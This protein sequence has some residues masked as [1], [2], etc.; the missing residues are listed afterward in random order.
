M[1]TRPLLCSALLVAGFGALLIPGAAS[2]RLPLGRNPAIPWKLH[3]AASLPAASLTGMNQPEFA[4]ADWIAAQVPGTVFSSCVA[5]GLEPDPNFGDNITKVDRTRYDQDFWY[6]TE[7][8]VPADFN[9]GRL[10]L[11]FLGVNRDAE[12]FLN[13]QRLGLI[14]GIVQRGRFDVT[15]AVRSAGPNVLTVLVHPPLAPVSNGASPTYGSSGGWDWMPSVPGYNS[16]IQDDVFVTTTGDVSIID[17]WIQAELPRLDLAQ[18]KLQVELL[19]SSSQG[20]KGH[21]VG[22][23]EPGAISFELPVTLGPRESKPITV[24]HQ[25]FPALAIANPAL[26]WPNGY[27]AP[28]LYRCELRFVAAS[29][30]SSDQQEVPFGIRQLEVDTSTRA[31]RVVVN[32][33]PIF[34]TGGNWGMPEFLLRGTPADYDTRV[35]LHQDM[36]FNMIRNWMGS[37]TNDAFYT[38]CDRYGILV[39][40][41]FWLNSSGGLPRDLLVFHAN[42]IEKLKRLRNH[43]CI[44]LWCGSNEGVPPAPLDEWLAT[45]VKTFDGR[46]YHSNSHSGSLSGSGPWT[47]LAPEEYFL[48]AAPGNWGGEE[49]WGMRSEMGAAAFVN[50]D[51]LKEFIPADKLWP[52]NDAWDRHFFGAAAMYAGPDTYAKAIDDR[53]GAPKGIEEFCRKAQLL[54]IETNK[55]MFEGWRDNLWHDATG[56]LIWM[57]QSAFPSMVWQTYDYYFDATGAYWG[58]KSACEPVH[59][60]WNLGTN[61][62]KAINNTRT[63][64]TGVHAE[65]R[66]YGLDG[67][68]LTKLKRS[69]T[70]DLAANAA[71][72]CFAAP[73][74]G[75]DLARGRPVTVS[76]VHVPSR[77]G[78]KLTDGR[79]D[80][81]WESDFA[82]QPWLIVD[83]GEPQSIGR[84]IMRWETGVHAHIYKLQTSADGNVWRDAYYQQDGRGGVEEVSFPAVTTRYLRMFCQEKATTVGISMRAFEVYADAASVPAGVHF[85]R[86]RLT[87]A[88]GSLLS[89]NLY[90]R[91]ARPL[92]YQ[93]LNTLPPVALESK[94]THSEAAGQHI[95]TANITNPAP[96][97][98]F[99]IRVQVVDARTGR[100]ILPIIASDSY[101]TLMRGETRTITVQFNATDELAKNAR[102]VLTPFNAPR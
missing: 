97:A 1:R 46:H 22:R 56:L 41:D 2:D 31:M 35:R 60:Q 79:E 89:E 70:L 102:L 77:E 96:T 16:G 59:I 85:L 12:V 82:A 62:V 61:S 47:G 99:A 51:S 100:R 71:T 10:W 34:V 68:E 88:D 15:T 86:L 23:I 32:G 20:I 27:G 42:S 101:F 78:D 11:N 73:P 39:W 50:L 3:A 48:R 87:S 63:A 55:A 28:N 5:S 49:G 57:S 94:V 7:F 37:T 33:V 52:R 80:T 4:T 9:R 72:P 90:W 24:D 81:R 17:P 45:N 36:N 40:D 65:A 66:I 84:V 8:P 19:N 6:R 13:G 21:L 93:E 38:A 44:A 75:G 26:W 76:S 18:L 14:Q 69:C 67:V 58:A 92:D 98:A 25:G 64:L 74:T 53:Y 54:N 91:G 83:L 43:P 95:L 29:G 30:A